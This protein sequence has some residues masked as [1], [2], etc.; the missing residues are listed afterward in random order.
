[1]SKVR[2]RVQ[3]GKLQG[4]FRQVQNQGQTTVLLRGDVELLRLLCSRNEC[5]PSTT[6]SG[7]TALDLA[8]A[9]GFEE[10]GEVLL[11]R[12]APLRHY[13][14]DTLLEAVERGSVLLL[15]ALLMQMRIYS[16]TAFLME[17]A[18]K[19]ISPQGVDGNTPLHLACTLPDREALVR[20]L[21]SHSAD[22]NIENDDGMTPLDL[23]G[24]VDMSI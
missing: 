4:G 2:K 10:G 18:A 13:K 24:D 17:A 1:M 19:A 12:E 7:V 21:V 8:V 15:R 6:W 3:E 20:V 11:Q 14:N 16:H 22:L 23:I 9:K 5:D